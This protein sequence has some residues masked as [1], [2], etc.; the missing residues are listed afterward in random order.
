MLPIQDLLNRIRWDREFK[1][2]RFEI[3]YYDRV[4]DR[5]IKVPFAEIEFP[6]GDHFS[7]RI[8]DEFE[9]PITIPF[10]RVR[11][12]WKDDLVIWERKSND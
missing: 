7:F 4:E 6:E 10:H 12:V 2:G 8:A 9:E 1:K 11:L 3:G 5:I